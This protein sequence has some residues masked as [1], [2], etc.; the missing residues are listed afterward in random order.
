MN[1]MNAVDTN[2]LIYALDVDE[3]VKQLKAQRLLDQLIP[4]RGETELLWQVAAEFLSCLRKWQNAGRIS[5][6]DVEANFRDITASFPLRLPVA[7]MFAASFGLS[8]RYSLSH[9]DSLLVA[10][11]KEAGIGVL[12]TENLDPG[13][14][15]DG[16]RIINPFA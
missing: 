9:W 10:G 7:S 5:A 6:E 15:Y 4:L 1:S 14:D 2:V 3:P 11:C 12:Y 13:T 16:V 8:S